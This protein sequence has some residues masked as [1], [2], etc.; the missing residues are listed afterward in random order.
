[1]LTQDDVSPGVHLYLCWKA[2]Y[3][4]IVV[5]IDIYS[6]FVASFQRCVLNTAASWAASVRETLIS[7]PTMISISSPSEPAGLCGSP[8]SRRELR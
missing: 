4:P 7:V 8:A 1:M 6:R 5:I 2:R 3:F